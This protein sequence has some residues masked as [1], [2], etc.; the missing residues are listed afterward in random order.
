MGLY[1]CY[2]DPFTSNCL[3]T[4]GVEEPD[5][6]FVGVRAILCGVENIAIRNEDHDFPFN[7]LYLTK[8]YFVQFSHHSSVSQT[9]GQI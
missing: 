6:K 4:F 9:D 8:H 1:H 5:P 3:A 2:R 7:S